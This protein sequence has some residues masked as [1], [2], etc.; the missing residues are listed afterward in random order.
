M[1]QITEKG[2]G[3]EFRHS[4]WMLWAILTF[5]ALNYISFYYISYKV[6]QR[7]W[8]IAGIIYSILFILVMVVSELFPT[9]HWVYD[10]TLAAYLLGWIASIVHVF[11][12]RP[13][14]LLRLEAKISS[15]HKEKEIASLKHKIAQEY[16]TTTASEK[17]D[18]TN[19]NSIHHEQQK[20]VSQETINAIK[21]TSTEIQIIDINTAS[22]QEI[23][24]IPGIGT[25]YAKKVVS[26]R[27][28]ENGFQS[29]DHFVEALSV[30]PHLI[31]KIKPHLSFPEN[32]SIQ[33]VKKP[34]GRIVDF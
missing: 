30:K 32:P 21:E 8:F 29:F 16:G 14:Y 19:T 1:A 5:G 20:M 6:K 3:W 18:N 34:E 27:S 2:K 28:Q 4:I 31:E 11:K 7:K 10:V 13:E 24:K 22:E 17:R 23:A 9:E 25:I 33:P 15:G 26:V 12:I